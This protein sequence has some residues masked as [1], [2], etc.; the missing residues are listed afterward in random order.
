MFS[1]SEDEQSEVKNTTFN[2]FVIF[3]RFE[4]ALKEAGFINNNG[5]GGSVEASWDKFI[6]KYKKQ[7]VVKHEFLNSFDYLTK[8]TTA[9]NKQVIQV[10]AED[11]LKAI[12]RNQSID[13]HAPELKKV[14]DSIKI[15]R[16]NLFHGGKYGHK[17][18]NDKERTQ[19]LIEHSI[20]AIFSFIELDETIR[21][22]FYDLA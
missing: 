1:L 13:P 11:E 7:Y 5:E 20:I 17:S 4:F 8:N 19:K 9:P 16:N 15:V 6:K 22:Y 12:W 21:Y 14:I 3:S 18:W 2:F 10:I